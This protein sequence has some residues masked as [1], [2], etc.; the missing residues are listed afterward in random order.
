MLKYNSYVFFM[1]FFCKHVQQKKQ[2][3]CLLLML[4]HAHT[5]KIIFVSTYS[6]LYQY[7]IVR[8]FKYTS[9]KLFKRIS[10]KKAIL[11]SLTNIATLKEHNSCV[12]LYVSYVCILKFDCSVIHPINPDSH[13]DLIAPNRCINYS[14]I[15]IQSLKEIQFSLR[16]TNN[17]LKNGKYIYGE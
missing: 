12:N 4:L 7:H 11:K 16:K 13:P 15:K 9:N 1:L 2:T 5:K 3:E 8:L 6:E 17:G 10:E 14:K